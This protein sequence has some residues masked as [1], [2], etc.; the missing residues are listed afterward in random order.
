VKGKRYNSAENSMKNVEP[1]KC[2]IG[3][4]VAWVARKMFRALDSLQVR[5]GEGLQARAR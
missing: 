4:Q 1:K 3:I 2:I 5:L